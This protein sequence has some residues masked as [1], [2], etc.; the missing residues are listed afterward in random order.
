VVAYAI[1]ECRLW[2]TYHSGEHP[3][4]LWHF[5]FQG[6]PLGNLPMIWLSMYHGVDE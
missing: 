2:C 5:H 6:A 1:D 4:A 3:E